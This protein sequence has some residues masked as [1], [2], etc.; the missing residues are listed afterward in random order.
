MSNVLTPFNRIISIIMFALILISGTAQA[1]TTAFAYQGQLTDGGSPANGIYDMQFKLFDTAD[2]GSGIQQG[3]TITNPSVQV[4]NGAFA[5]TLDFGASVFTGASRFLEVGVR[6]AGDNNPYTILAPRQTIASTPYAIRSLSAANADSATNAAQLGGINPGGFIQN[7]TMQQAGV[8]FNVGGNGTLGGT[9]SANVVDVTTHYTIAGNRV[10]R[11]ET[12][13]GNLFVGF[14]TGEGNT[15]G[16]NNA[17][18]GTSAGGLNETGNQNA[19]FGN[20]AGQANQAG[21]SNSFFGYAAGALNKAS[22]NSFFGARAG[23]FNLMGCCN[24]F[25]GHDAG[26]SNQN[27]SL[28]AFFGFQ[29]GVNN[30]ASEN[31]F[32]GA[33]AGGANTVGTHNSF[34]GANAGRFNTTGS[35]NSFFGFQSGFSNTSGTGNSFFGISAGVNNTE[36]YENSF[37]G[38]AAGQGTT[39]GHDNAFFGTSV[40]TSNTSGYDNAFFGTEAGFYNTTGFN[41]AFFGNYAGHANTTGV[42]NSFFGIGAGSA[43]TEGNFNTFIGAEANGSDGANGSTAI[44]YRAYVSQSNSLVLG[45][46]SGFNNA[47]ADTSVGIGTPAPKTKLHVAGGKIYIEANGQ[48]IILKSPNA[49]CFEVTVNDMGVLETVPVSCPK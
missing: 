17:F 21:S 10:L 45:S 13:T 19:F 12:G 25:F 47:I 16:T 29:A 31:S 2:V 41:N 18:F 5:I 24:A 15:S 36:G 40:G 28:N 38:Y 6:T 49:S 39:D 37:F 9:L 1:Q 32:F 22:S 4:T 11:A 34:F 3:S 30:T 14:N 35:L 23:L 33:F 27:G 7:S 46:I 8:S 44:G 42:G 48:G 43:N 26:G 20:T